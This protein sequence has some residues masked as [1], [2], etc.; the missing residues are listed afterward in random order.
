MLGSLAV[1]LVVGAD[2]H[3]VE[4]VED[5]GLHHAELGGSVEHAGVLQSGQVEPTAATGPPV[6]A[7]NSWPAARRASPVSSCSS[8]GNGPEPTRVQY[9]LKMPMT[10]PM[11]VG[12]TP[13]PVQAPAAVVVELVT[14]G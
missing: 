5:V 11:R 1:Q 9:A 7:P 13:S 8:V 6:V 3:F 12:A 14:K 2:L 10:S 4:G